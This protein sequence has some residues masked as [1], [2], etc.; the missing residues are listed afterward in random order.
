MLCRARSLLQGSGLVAAVA[1]QLVRTSSAESV[2][3][4]IRLCLKR[5]QK[6]QTAA[7]DWLVSAVARHCW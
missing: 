4:L 3:W 6:V 7:W 2:A 5:V 1:A